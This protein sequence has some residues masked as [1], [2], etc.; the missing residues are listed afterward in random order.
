MKIELSPQET[1]LLRMLLA[2]E[3]EEVRVEVHHAKNIDFKGHLQAREQQLQAIL[4]K[5][6]IAVSV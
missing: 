3:R 6:E 2:K 1:D 4:G 5:L